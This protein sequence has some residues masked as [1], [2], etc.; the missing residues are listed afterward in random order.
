[1][2][3]GRPPPD[4]PVRRRV[5]DPG[6]SFLVQAPA[7]AGKTELLIQ[8]YL[9]LLATVDQPEDVLAV[10][11]TRKAAGE[12]RQ[13]I[14]KALDA[15]AQ[16]G[17]RVNADTLALA[18]AVLERD[19]ARGWM[20]R[21]HPARLRISTIDSLNS[22]IA[23][24]APVT[25]GAS[26][27]R[28]V[29]EK[30]A[31]SYAEAARRVVRHPADPERVGDAVTVLLWH[32]DNQVDRLEK[33]IAAMLGTRDQWL[34]LTGMGN[35]DDRARRRSMEQSLRRVVMHRLQP[36]PDALPPALLGEVREVMAAIAESP[37]REIPP[38]PADDTT[39]VSA[40]LR[41]WRCVAETFLTK[42]DPAWR[43]RLDKRQGFPPHRKALKGR[44]LDLL[45]HLREC[46]GLLTLLDDVRTLPEPVYADDQW[47]VLQAL[48][49]VLQ[50]AA[51]EL[52]LL[53]AETGDTDF[54][55]IAGA[56]HQALGSDDEP[57]EAGLRLDARVRHILMDEFQDTSRTQFELLN[58]LTRGWSDGDGRTVFLVGDP[59][60]SIYGFRQ[61]EVR[62]FIEARDRNLPN[63]KLEFVRLTANFRSVPAVVDW[64]NDT[65]AHVMP[66][67][68]DLFTGAVSYEPAEAQ[69]L[70]EEGTGV[71]LH[72]TSGRTPADEG[73]EIATLVAGCLQQRP[74]STIGILV[75]SRAHA[76]ETLQALKARGIGTTAV[77]LWPLG[78]TGLV[79]DLLALT[80]ALV[81]RGDRLAWLGTLRAPWC[82]LTL[83]D[84][85]ALAGGDRKATVWSL[86]N[87]PQAVARLSPDG[88][89][90]IARLLEAWRRADARLG[91]LD[92]RDVVEGLWIEL[93]GPAV[94]GADIEHADTLFDVLERHDLGGDCADTVALA[95]ELAATPATLHDSTEQVRVLTIHKAKGLEFDTVIVPGLGRPTKND[96]RPMLLWEDL[97][98]PAGPPELLLAP[99]NAA[100]T[101]EDRL[102]E[103]LWRLRQDKALAETDRLLYVAATRAKRCLHL[104]GQV[105]GPAGKPAGGSLLERLWPRLASRWPHRIG[106]V[107]PEGEPPPAPVLEPADVTAGWQQAPLRRLR[108]DWQRPAPPSPTVPAAATSPAEEALLYDWASLEAMHAG[109]VVHRWL[110]HLASAG[111]AGGGQRYTPERLQALMPVFR[112]MLQRL[113]V[114]TDRLD[115]AAARVRDALLRTLEDGRGRWILSQEHEHGAVEYA[116]TV[117]DGTT[118]RRLVIDRTFVDD[119]GVRWIIDYKTG[120]H[121][122]G[123]TTAFLASEEQRYRQQLSA[124]RAAFT[125]L[126]DRTV[127]TALYFPL[128]GIFHEVR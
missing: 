45:G 105:D 1:M 58:A 124:Y 15:P 44:A 76:A 30:A 39:D 126:E 121:E 28:R 26:V 116:L 96:A 55:E 71:F 77:D 73:G 18:R 66:S 88:Q 85:V 100:G 81:H 84:L 83:A 64:V 38:A 80:R 91:Q 29:R 123:D 104:F 60:Q 46:P 86:L 87:D 122:G 35:G 16:A 65:F 42:T 5:L 107:G 61:A 27:L 67:A 108:G 34:P 25:G 90:R 33:L 36:L 95:E 11:F 3:I 89:A 52:K 48:L 59:M 70:A 12:M 118:P 54:I 94:A 13:R 50:L 8:R 102:Y 109:A 49:T 101:D 92:L 31:P 69:H 106:E 79:A 17:A 113:G 125:A 56:A 114:A 7:G 75:R 57:G 22:S 99:V 82:G 2:I 97:L 128:L 112:R 111:V 21:D 78:R 40:A 19:G 115:D 47:R 41:W 120:S 10:T 72:D 37:D 63:V 24:G 6:T 98:I 23:R 20:L 103:M 43:A 4:D 117:M 127:C 68:D 14:M 32:L 9:R 51:A 93:G 110:Q 53:F 74:G 119:D 62:L